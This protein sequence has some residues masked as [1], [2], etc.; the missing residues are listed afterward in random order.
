MATH[1]SVLAWRIPGTGEPA[2]LPSLGSHRVGHDW[3][4]LAA[5]AAAHFVLWSRQ[6]F[7][8]WQSRTK[9]KPFRGWIDLWVFSVSL[10]S[11]QNSE[12]VSKNPGLTWELRTLTPLHGP[13]WGMLLGILIKA[14]LLVWLSTYSHMPV[15]PWSNP[16]PG[17]FLS[18]TLA[19]CPCFSI[20]ITNAH[21]TEF[22][23]F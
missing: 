2:G 19:P 5:A 8:C 7:F 16:S 14:S 4:N 13:R 12:E 20:C 6:L 9:K 23:Q 17:S 15:K 10:L 18:S 1:S 22:P 3:S 21:N 11:H